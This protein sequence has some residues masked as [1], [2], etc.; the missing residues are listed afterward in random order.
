MEVLALKIAIA[1]ALIV[2]LI[3]SVS[4]WREEYDYYRLSFRSIA[5]A[6]F[7]GFCIGCLAFLVAFITAG[8]V[9]FLIWG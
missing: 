6:A 5:G 2:W 9:A 3:A 7:W 4:L 1:V 8:A